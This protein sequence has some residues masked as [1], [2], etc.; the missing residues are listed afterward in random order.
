MSHE[1]FEYIIQMNAD[2]AGVIVRKDAPWQNI[3]QLIDHIRRNPGKLQ[4]SGTAVGGS[5]DLSRIGM[6]QAAGLPVDSTVW[7]PSQGAAPAIVE[8]L[9]GHIDVITCSL[10]E[11]QSQLE[12]GDFRALAVM[13]DE[14]QPGFPNVPT[15]K[16]SGINWSSEAWRGITVP[17]GTPP[18]IVRMLR[19]R[20]QQIARSDAYREFMSRNGF[21]IVIRV[22][23]EFARYAAEQDRTWQTIIR[24]SGYDQ[25]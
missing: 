12:S 1:A 19:E 7:I 10:P 17:K 4:F 6:I 5:W 9:G 22:G 11:A 14:R 16:E 13:S 24:A 23:D 21:G 20:A 15:L 3:G 18:E 8:L 2:P 25:R